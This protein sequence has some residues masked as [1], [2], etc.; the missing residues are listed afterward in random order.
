M[1]PLN[2]N[3][4]RRMEEQRRE[5]RL[6]RGV[7]CLLR[8]VKKKKSGEHLTEQERRFDALLTHAG[9]YDSESEARSGGET[10]GALAKRQKTFAADSIANCKPASL[11]DEGESQPVPSSF[12]VVEPSLAEDCKLASLNEGATSGCNKCQL[13]LKTGEKTRKRHDQQCPRRHS[14]RKPCSV[15]GCGKLALSGGKCSGHGGGPRCI[16]EGCDKGAVSGGKCA[17]HGGGERCSVVGCDKVAKSGGKCIGH[18]G[19]AR[20][21]VEDCGKGAKSG[22]KCLDHGGGR[23][24]VEDCDKVAMYGGKCLDHGGDEARE[25]KL[26]QQ[27]EKS[28]SDRAAMKAAAVEYKATHGGGTLLEYDSAEADAVLRK[29]ALS[30]ERLHAAFLKYGKDEEL[31]RL[32]L[33]PLTPSQK[34]QLAGTEWCLYAGTAEHSSLYCKD[35][36]EHLRWARDSK[37]GVVRLKE[38]SALYQ[39]NVENRYVTVNIDSLTKEQARAIFGDEFVIAFESLTEWEA[40]VV[41]GRIHFLLESAEVGAPTSLDPNGI[42]VTRMWKNADKGRRDRFGRYYTFLK[43]GPPLSRRND[44]RYIQPVR[45]SSTLQLAPS[46]ASFDERRQDLPDAVQAKV[47]LDTISGAVITFTG[48]T[49]GTSTAQLGELAIKRGATK[50]KDKNATKDM[51]L[52]VVLGTVDE[53]AKP[54]AKE[55]F[56][57][58]NSIPIMGGDDFIALVKGSAKSSGDSLGRKRKAYS[59]SADAAGAGKAPPSKQAK[60]GSDKPL[61]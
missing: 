59:S 18:G 49:I 36:P 28:A 45:R 51:T 7:R 34:A 26:Q 56:A 5:L 15:E 29:I 4:Q 57:R 38:D 60:G 20:C 27:R 46:R 17:A 19:G 13:E 43:W 3:A 37:Y 32:N 47:A 35:N 14:G 16:V 44:L 39:E 12:A 21:S 55:R 24:S 42:T 41:E 11:N 9:F 6:R 31:E 61:S 30:D 10:T 54:S 1:L 2:K 58:E 50:I 22:G 33:P 53:N 40:R 25:R 23:C 8:V 48:K 52:L